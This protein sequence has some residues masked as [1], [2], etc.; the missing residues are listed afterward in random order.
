MSRV[1]PSIVSRHTAVL[2][3]IATVV[4]VVA[5]AHFTLAPRHDITDTDRRSEAQRAGQHSV[6]PPGLRVC[7]ALTHS[8]LE[9]VTFM[10]HIYK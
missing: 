3:H 2:Y 1:K 8:V 10:H 9:T 7:V 4:T 6:A 5:S